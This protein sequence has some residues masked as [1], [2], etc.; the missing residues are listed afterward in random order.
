MAKPR[1]G[2]KPVNRA[3]NGR[4]VAGGGSLNP[5]G[6]PKRVAELRR[7][8][9]DKAEAWLTRLDEL[10]KCGDP[11]VEVMAL[12]TAIPRAL[13]RESSPDEMVDDT[14]LPPPGETTP[15][16]LLTRALH[17]LER[18]LARREAQLAAGT[19]LSEGQLAALGEQAQTLATL[20]RE[21]R[22]LAKSPPGAD[23]SDEALID[24]VLAAVPKEKLKAAIAARGKA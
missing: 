18:S 13:G 9:L 24:Q 12:K 16:A 1:K 14:P 8:A 2:N 17:L 22:E 7:I 3:P 19:A 15:A 20:A 4:V 23:L 21:E 10:T 5:G 11:M 6:M